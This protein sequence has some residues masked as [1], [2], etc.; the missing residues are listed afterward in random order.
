MING[1]VSGSLKQQVRN[2][3]SVAYVL[4]DSANGDR[5][6]GFY[7]IAQH[8]IHQSLLSAIEQ[9]SLPKTVPCSRLIMLGVDKEYKGAKLGLQLMKHAFKTV[10]LASTQIAAYGVYLDADSGALDFYKKLGF[11]LLD[12]DKS[13]E[14]SPM[15]IPMGSIE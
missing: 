4:T 8:T 5:F 14:P 1:F 12:G 2:G 10:K 15:F 13:P 3:L 11:Q 6:V 9:R 7:T